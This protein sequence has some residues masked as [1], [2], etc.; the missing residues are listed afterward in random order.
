MVVESIMYVLSPHVASILFE[1]AGIA[2]LIY[3]WQ[4]LSI[5]RMFERMY[6]GFK[7]KIVLIL[8]NVVINLKN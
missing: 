5:I 6:Q 8:N 7:G 1:D 2:V 3:A 4:E